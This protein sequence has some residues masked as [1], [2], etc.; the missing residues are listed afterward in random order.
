MAHPA[1]AEL[2]LLLEVPGLDDEGP[3]RPNVNLLKSIRKKITK[4]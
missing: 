1:F 3:D 2:P 4:S